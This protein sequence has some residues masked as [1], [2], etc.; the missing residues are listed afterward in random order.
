M[1]ATDDVPTPNATAPDTAE[2]E[3]TV[4][5]ASKTPR[6]RTTK[7]RPKAAPKKN[8]QSAE[9]P[10]ITQSI[11]VSAAA[12]TLSG[13]AAVED[14][15]HPPP[16]AKKSRP[17]AAGKTAPKPAERTPRKRSAAKS[18]SADVEG[19]APKSNPPDS[20]LL[21]LPGVG[22]G[23]LSLFSACGVTSM[24]ELAAANADKLRQKMGLPG[25]LLNLERWIEEAQKSQ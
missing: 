12:Q 16:R 21:Q 18:R 9:T 13:T 11:Q 6:K 17:K 3:T 25:E 10:P 7:R 23:L 5:E 15:P 19:T 1:P 22:T 24:G 20:D 4:S 2:V 8:A 14:A